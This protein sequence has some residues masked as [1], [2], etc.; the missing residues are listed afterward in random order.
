MIASRLLVLATAT[1]ATPVSVSCVGDSITTDAGKDS[2]PAQLGALL[3][4]G[5]N[6]T[7][8]GV[9]GHTM[10]INGLCAATPAGSWRRPC[11]NIKDAQ[12][13]SGNCSYWG[14][15]EYQATLDANP[16]IIT[17]MLGTNDAKGCNWDSDINGVPAG[18]GTRFAADY[19]LM[20][21]TFKALPSNPKV[22]V[23]LPPPGISQCAVTG[24]A[25]NSS[26]C[27]AYNMSFH[28]INEVYPVL[29][30]Q[31][32]SVAGADGVIDVWSALNGTAC[33]AISPCPTCHGSVPSPPCPHTMDGIHPYPDGLAVI[34]KTIA[35]TIMTSSDQR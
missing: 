19:T 5:Y 14:T 12:P 26:V 7:N 31:I 23:V 13:C 17:I 33:T 4:P 24:P 16:D 32:A 22:F 1:G 21:K 6:V 3:G 2:Y 10:L 35:K 20:I 11:L 8:R 34:A 25:G 9:S 15:D 27:L 18:N 30:R 28:A 29:Q